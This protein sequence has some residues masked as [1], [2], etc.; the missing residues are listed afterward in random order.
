LIA[1]FQPNQP[2]ALRVAADHGNVLDRC[3]H[4]DARL[5]H[6][7][8]LVVHAHLKGADH[9]AVAVGDL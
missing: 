8:D 4:Q 9:P 1:L 3:P 5:A 7:H 2:H 6:Q